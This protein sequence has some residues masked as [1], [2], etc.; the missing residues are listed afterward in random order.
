V[1]RAF[2]SFFYHPAVCTRGGILLV[3]NFGVV[4][5]SNPHFSDNTITAH[6]GDVAATGWWFI[7]VYGPQSDVDKCL[8]LC[9]L[10]ELRDLH[11]DPWVV[12]GDFNLIV[13]A[14]D[15]KNAHL[16]RRMIGKFRKLLAEVEMKELYLNSMGE[17]GADTGG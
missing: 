17:N 3:W 4:A 12:V 8:F 15:K 11:P 10:K 6:V 16:N 1:G 9:E 13:D 14:T 2:D 7:G 5:L